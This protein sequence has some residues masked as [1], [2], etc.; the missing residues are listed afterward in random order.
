MSKRKSSIPFF[1]IPI[2][3]AVATA[4]IF[5]RRL[6]KK[7][8]VIPEEIKTMTKNAVNDIENTVV[9]L[10]EA[11]ENKSVSHLEKNIDNAVE[12]AKSSIDKIA[13][14]IKIQL[15]NF[16]IQNPQ[17]QNTKIV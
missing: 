8:E 15:K 16:D 5:I 9:D 17:S 3:V 2:T 12:N 6:F 1:V 10:K 7:K 11:I 4:S 13:T 14:H